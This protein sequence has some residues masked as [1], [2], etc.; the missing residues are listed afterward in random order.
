[1]RRSLLLFAVGVAAAVTT[2]SACSS[3]SPGQGRI[4]T[5]HRAPTSSTAPKSPTDFPS[6]TS[7]SASSTAAAGTCPAKAGYCAQFDG[8]ADGW[9]VTNQ[10]DYFAQY[11]SYSG[12]TYRLGQRSSAT[13]VQQAP[14]DITKISHD[15]SVQIDVDAIPYHSMPLSTSAGIDCWEHKS[16]GHTAAFLF[17]VD[18]STV[19]IGLWDEFNG[20]YHKIASK[21]DAGLVK[22]DG[23]PNHLT[24]ACVQGEHHGGV[25]AE[26]GIKING[27]VALVTSYDKSVHNYE[28]SVGPGV[29]LLASGKGADVFYD[30]FAVTSLC[31]GD[32]C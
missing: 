16:N 13:E 24:V 30:N 27:K 22:T 23:S 2:V 21:S 6:T 32:F 17:F 11:T 4:S 14:V 26:L 1:V 10:S 31:H 28:W 20:E 9:P 7:S 15:Y 29:G 19:E 5:S 8:S 18:P 12:G 3:S 25:T